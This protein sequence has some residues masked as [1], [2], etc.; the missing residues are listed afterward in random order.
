MKKILGLT[1]T[2]IL[3]TSCFTCPKSPESEICRNS[4]IITDKELHICS[5]IEV[6]D[7]QSICI[8]KD[9]IFSTEI[10]LNLAPTTKV[11]IKNPQNHVK[12]SLPTEGYIWD[13]WWGYTDY[14]PSLPQCFLETCFAGGKENFKK[15]GKIVEI[16][17]EGIKKGDIKV[18]FK[19]YPC[20]INGDPTVKYNRVCVKVDVIV[21]DNVKEGYYTEQ[22]FNYRK[23][24]NYPV[25]ELKVDTSYFKKDTYYFLKD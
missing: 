15:L 19:S 24:A 8:L 6:T 18:N 12:F 20:N 13:T 25:I 22:L 10:P 11:L 23:I 21:P 2:G 17:N 5:E 3:L 1:L 9:E 14:Y 7:G 4:W 16:L